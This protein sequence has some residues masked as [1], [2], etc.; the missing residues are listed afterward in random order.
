[1]RKRSWLVAAGLGLFLAGTRLPASEYGR[2]ELTVVVDGSTAAEY[3]F[4]DR[5]YIEALR[6]WLAEH[7][8]AV[9]QPPTN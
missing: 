2:F 4:R 6:G 1:M 7:R 9:I 3:P 5:T 8:D